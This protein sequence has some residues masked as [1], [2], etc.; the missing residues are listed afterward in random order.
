MSFKKCITKWIYRILRML[1]SFA[2]FVISSYCSY[3]IHNS[4]LDSISIFVF[5]SLVQSV[6]SC[7]EIF[8]T[9][10]LVCCTLFYWSLLRWSLLILYFPIHFPPSLYFEDPLHSFDY[11]YVSVREVF[12]NILKLHHVG[13]GDLFKVCLDLYDVNNHHVHDGYIL[14]KACS[15]IVNI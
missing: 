6:S 9:K 10:Q 12:Y 1:V 5:N 4:L 11:D 7:L 2:E 14:V 3:K 8:R 13:P 15:F